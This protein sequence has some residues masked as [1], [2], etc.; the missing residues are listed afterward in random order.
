MQFPIMYKWAKLRGYLLQDL[1]SSD[2]AGLSM[3]DVF[4]R[5]ETFLWNNARLLERRLFAF[6]FQDGAREAVLA[7]LFAYQNAD[8]GFGNALEPDIRCPESQPVPVQHALGILDTVG[9]DHAIMQPICDYLMTITTAEGG[10]PWLL[11][12]AGAY[13]HAP[14]WTTVDSPPASLNPTAAIVALLQKHHIEHPWIAPA[15]AYCWKQIAHLQLTDMHELGVVLEF[16]SYVPD[17]SRA[18][19]ELARLVGYLLSSGLV[20][21]ANS[22]GYVRKPLD[23]APTPYHRLRPYF[24]AEQIQAHLDAIGAD[25]LAD[26]GWPIT[27]DALSPSCALEWRGWITLS[28]LLTLR[29]NGRLQR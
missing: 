29:A 27:W 20:A 12:S 15:T 23:W 8:G 10:V 18:E 24:R 3:N 1:G 28:T 26:G 7:A 2:G 16:L 11:P 9:F 14:W 4:T 19:P 22:T 6:H 17:R 13:P 21:D 25:Q 5:A